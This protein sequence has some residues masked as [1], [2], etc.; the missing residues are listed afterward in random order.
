[1][2]FSS[3]LIGGIAGAALA[4]YVMNRKSSFRGALMSSGS[5]TGK[6][7]SGMMNEALQMFSG[8]SAANSPNQSQAGNSGHSDSKAASQGSSQ[9]SSYPQHKKSHSAGSASN[10]AQDEQM[11]KELIAK[12][13][14]VKSA[15]DEILDKNDSRTSGTH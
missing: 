13:S 14:H 7:V 5:S 6:A 8:K 15:V 10:S 3:M 2:R 1:M 4:V 11:I 9:S 12:D